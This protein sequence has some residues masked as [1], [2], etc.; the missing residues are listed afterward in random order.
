MRYSKINVNFFKSN[1]KKIIN[2]LKPN[3]LVIINSNDIMPKDEDGLMSFKQNNDI[4]YFSGIEQENTILLLYPDSKNKIYKEIL[5]LQKP[6]NLID[7]WDGDKYT[8]KSASMVSGVF[9]IY[10]LDSFE[11]ILKILAY[12][13]DNIY[14]N[15]NEHTRSCSNVQTRDERFINWC[16]NKYPLHSYCRIAPIIYKIRSIKSEFE[17]N[18][19]RKAIKI[20]ETGLKKIFSLL[21]PGIME[22]EIEA[23]LIYEFINFRSKGFGFSPI[24]A[25][26]VNNCI[27]HYIKNNQKCKSNDLLLLDIGAEYANYSSDVTRVLPI[28]GRFNKRQKEVYSVVLNTLN[29]AKKIILPGLSISNYNK[30]I[31]SF[32]QEEFLSLKLTKDKKRFKEYFP[33]NITHYL[34]LNIHDVGDINKIFKPGMVLTIEP[35]IYIKEEGFGIRLENNIV[36]KNNSIEDITKNIPIKIE[37]I[38][39]LMN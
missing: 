38:E 32:M 6:N 10:W 7:A 3:S 9:S 18:L 13:V 31:N 8:K 1:R 37:E 4:F 20:T 19:I 33:H 21:K 35:G 2:Y 30:E 36:I 24:I 26:G 39:S 15:T 27:L 12:Q 11:L 23:K 16:K 28:N 17:I 34:G 22:Y 29:Y 5:F 25:S 14:L